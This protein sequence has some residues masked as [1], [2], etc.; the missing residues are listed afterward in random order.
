MFRF[1]S[2][3]NPLRS[4]VRIS[5]IL[6]ALAF[7]GAG[8]ALSDIGPAS[9]SVPAAELVGKGRMTFLGFKLFE[10]EL[11]APQ[12]TYRPSAPFALKLTYLRNFKSSDIAGSSVKEIKRQGGVSAQQ[13]AAWKN[14]MERIFPDISAGQSITGVRAANGSSV[15]YL[16]NRKLGTIS[17]PAFTKRFFSIWLGT[18]TRDPQLRARLVG[19]RS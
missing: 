9:R 13:L 10:A 14:E 17:D 18:R 19:A 12:G 15:F 11:Y 3:K 5:V 2:R 1:P 16:G 7:T 6:A 4:T 8:P